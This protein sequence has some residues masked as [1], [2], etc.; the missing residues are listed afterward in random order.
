METLPANKILPA[1]E[2]MPKKDYELAVHVVELVAGY[3]NISVE[4]LISRR[5][6]EAIATA[7][8]IVWHLLRWIQPR[9][10]TAQLAAILQRTHGSVIVGERT[11][12]DLLETMPY[13]RK[14]IDELKQQLTNNNNESRNP[15]AN[16][17]DT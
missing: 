17:G 15:E 9:L 13:M 12:R 10:T 1:I 5:R 4:S 6:T 16:K 11:L 7:R 14:D 2:G 8:K 3:Y